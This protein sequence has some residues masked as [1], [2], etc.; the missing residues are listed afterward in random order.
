MR[1]LVK[2]I[3][4]ESNQI[5]WVLYEYGKINKPIA[6]IDD[7]NMKDIKNEIEIGFTEEAK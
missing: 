7:L 5:F 3:K 1:I 6:I 2:P 4:D